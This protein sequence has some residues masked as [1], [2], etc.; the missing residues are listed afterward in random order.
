MNNDR[1]DQFENSLRRES[2]CSRNGINR[3]AKRSYPLPTMAQGRLSE[4]YEDQSTPRRK[5]DGSLPGVTR[6]G[7]GSL[8]WGL[9]E[10]PL[11]MVYSPYQFWR[12]M[13][14]PDVALQRGTLF[15]ELDLPFEGS[16]RKG[17]C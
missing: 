11:A 10:Y 2:T 14:T 12:G 6:D 17:G 1:R 4:G 15:G 5:C 16:G 13:Y 9:E 3:T 7:S 8:G